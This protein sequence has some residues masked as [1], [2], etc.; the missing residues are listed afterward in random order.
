[1]ASLVWEQ[2][3]Q[4]G[5]P[6]WDAAARDVMREVQRNAGFNTTADP[7][8]PAC[9]QL[10]APK[11]AEAI[12]RQSLPPNQRNATS[13]DYTDMTWHAPTAR[14]YIARPALAGGPYPPWAMNALGGIP[15]TIDPMVQ[16]ASKVLALSALRVL[17]DE[18]ARVAAM[19]EF[20]RRTSENAIP[21]L[22]DYPSP[23]RFPW[24]E[25]VTTPRG[26]DW[27]IPILEAQ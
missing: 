1:M 23:H 11:D 15:A 20:K 7:L 24:P 5:A 19:K 25:Y 12:L 3:Q 9:E 2:I 22:C 17:E 8:L 27:H 26:T 10:I 16:V 13:D 18:S 6:Q 21:P 4:V 14:F